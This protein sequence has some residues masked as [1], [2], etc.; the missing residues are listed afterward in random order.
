[1]RSSSLLVISDSEGFT[2]SQVELTDRCI[3]T[4]EKPT[5]EWEVGSNTHTHRFKVPGRGV[6]QWPG[7]SVRMQDHV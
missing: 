5:G 6:T 7:Q 1:M 2:A 4:L 3:W